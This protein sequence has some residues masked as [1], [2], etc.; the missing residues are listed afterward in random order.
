VFEV[1]L[2][3]HFFIALHQE[4]GRHMNDQDA[5]NAFLL[6]YGYGQVD[7]LSESVVR[8]WA[9]SCCG[10]YEFLV[11][12]STGNAVYP[13]HDFYA[14][15]VLDRNYYRSLDEVIRARLPSVVVVF[16]LTKPI[17]DQIEAWRL[18]REE[19]KRHQ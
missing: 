12:I 4:G 15:T 14:A 7:N 10:D 18:I 1:V 3:L 5:S 13:E 17:D 8:R 9:R 19:I 11:V 2:Y 6:R 16:S